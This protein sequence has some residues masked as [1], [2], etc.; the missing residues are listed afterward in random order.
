MTRARV[1]AAVAA[2]ITA[3]LLQ[4]ALVTPL[5][6]TIAVSLPA[7]LVAAVALVE[8]PGTGVAFGFTTGLVAD[9]GSN[10]PAG[11]LALCW[12]GLGAG[13][14]MSS[15]HRSRLADIAYTGVGCAVASA[16]VTLLLIAVHADGATLAALPTAVGV[17]LLSA[18]LA[19][20]VVPLVRRVLRSQVLAAPRAVGT[21]TFDLER[22]R[23]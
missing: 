6:P 16:A 22:L 3:L 20:L 11:I 7:V 2:I 12:L 1:A 10:H 23:G 14:G 17:G 4:A 13:L 5:S 21:A 9:L 8:G 18:G 19:V 15:Q